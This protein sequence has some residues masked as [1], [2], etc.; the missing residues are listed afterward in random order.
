MMERLLAQFDNHPKQNNGLSECN[1]CATVL[2][3]NGADSVLKLHSLGRI[4]VGNCGMCWWGVQA[5]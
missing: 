3:Q 2:A 5:V 4:F 1:G